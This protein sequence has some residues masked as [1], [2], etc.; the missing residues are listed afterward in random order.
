MISPVV[1]SYMEV[2]L[3]RGEGVGR[4]IPRRGVLLVRG[5]GLVLALGGALEDLHVKLPPLDVLPG[6]LV[7]DHDDELRDLAA[8]HPLVQLGHDPLDVRLDLVVGR[9]CLPFVSVIVLNWTRGRK[10]RT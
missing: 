5:L 1:V 2:R 9:Y 6:I 8:H 10:E 7:G 4:Y 3:D